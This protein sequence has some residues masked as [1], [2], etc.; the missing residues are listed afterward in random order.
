VTITRA[1]ADDRIDARALTRSST[2]CIVPVMCASLDRLTVHADGST[3]ST[4]AP[5]PQQGQ[6]HDD[7]R[8][9]IVRRRS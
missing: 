8:F 2:V 1:H 3:H 4:S 9:G 7:A 6:T 5:S